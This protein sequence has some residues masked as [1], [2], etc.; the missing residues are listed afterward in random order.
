MPDDRTTSPMRAFSS[1]GCPELN[2][3]ETLVLARRHGLA[4][5]ELRALEGSVELPALFARNFGTPDALGVHLSDATL[6]IFGLGTSVR[7]LEAR[8]GDREALLAYVPWAEAARV[9][10]LRIFDGGTDGGAAEFAH[11]AALF[12]W[13]DEVRAAGGWS[14]DL[15]V[16]THDAIALPATL[17]RYVAAF[18][19]R[20]LLW[21]AHHTWRK[22]GADPVVT[23][24]LVAPVTRH[25]H[26]KDSVSR[27]GPRL[28]YTYVIPGEG[29]FPMAP[30]RAALGA[31]RYSGVLSLEWERMW[32]TDL[33]PL[34]DALTG[35]ETHRWW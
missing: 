26:V 30:L 23:W 5:V 25:I 3:D 2:L 15:I 19:D 6:R 29:E 22:G 27:P 32:H 34:E 16:E 13:W 1:L 11:A 14:V 18:P 35:A 20:H 17:A 7:L 8:D 31:R 28:P 10:Y 12:R 9:P 21:D 33:A 4:G 24:P